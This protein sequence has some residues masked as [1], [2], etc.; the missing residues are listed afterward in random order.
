MADDSMHEMVAQQRLQGE[1]LD[2]ATQISTGQDGALDSRALDTYLFRLPTT[3]CANVI[4]PNGVTQM[5]RI[6]LEYLQRI[7]R[8]RL[9]D[10]AL[11]DQ[12][13]RKRH[14][15]DE[16]QDRHGG[17]EPRLPPTDASIRQ[18]ASEHDEQSRQ[19]PDSIANQCLASPAD[20]PGLPPRAGP[21]LVRGRRRGGAVVGLGAGWLGC[22]QRTR[23]SIHR[24]PPHSSTH[25]HKHART[26][27]RTCTHA[28][29]N[30]RA[31]THT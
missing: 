3:C 25:G 11:G 7:T 28:R 14:R 16:T 20:R 18:R 31:H 29:T 21:R 1:I 10:N 27:A 24:I 5:M 17:G 12:Q 22:W 8:K 4:S 19:N 13:A 15:G 30:A 23:C 9:A 6:H 26:H 2:L